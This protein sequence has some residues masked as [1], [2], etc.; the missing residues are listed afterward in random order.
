MQA[1]Q[2]VKGE[3]RQGGEAYGEISCVLYCST[4]EEDQKRSKTK[5]NWYKNKSHSST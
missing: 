5:Q 3:T 2:A 4:K 1:W